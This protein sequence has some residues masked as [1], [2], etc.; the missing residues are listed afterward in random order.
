VLGWWARR[1]RISENAYR[2]LRQAQ[3]R[4]S[5]AFV[6]AFLAPLRSLFI[7]RP[8]FPKACAVGFIL[9]PPF[10]FAQGKLS[11]LDLGRVWSTVLLWSLVLTHSQWPGAASSSAAAF[12]IAAATSSRTLATGGT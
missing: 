4:L 1:V 7:S 8:P 11:Q 12:A 10:E 5:G 2:L 9:A 6:V 3:G